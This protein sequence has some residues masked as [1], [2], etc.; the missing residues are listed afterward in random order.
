MKRM[1]ILGR[2]VIIVMLY[3]LHIS[4]SHAADVTHYRFRVNNAA[5]A[6]VVLHHGFEVNNKAGVME[7]LSCHDGSVAIARSTGDHPVNRPYPPIDK[8]RMFNNPAQVKAAGIIL[9]QGR[10]TCV[11][12]HNLANPKP[13]HLVIELDRSTLCLTCHIK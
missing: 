13:P 2:S 11:S 8:R 4:D 5:M 9:V 1:A 12:C 6:D 7:C 3:A 10:V